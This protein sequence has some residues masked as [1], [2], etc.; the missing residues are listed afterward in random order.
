MSTTLH[1]VSDQCVLNWCH[2]PPNAGG[3]V[4]TSYGAWTVPKKNGGTKNRKHISY[5]SNE[6]LSGPLRGQTVALLLYPAGLFIYFWLSFETFGLSSNTTSWNSIHNHIHTLSLFF[7]K[8]SHMHFSI[9]QTNIFE[10]NQN[11]ISIK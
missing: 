2:Y 4:H 6:R 1:Y 11:Y 3:N 7:F 8:T 9:F 10:I 5:K